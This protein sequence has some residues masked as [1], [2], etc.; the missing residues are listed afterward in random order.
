MGSLS[1]SLRRPLR[2]AVAAKEPS[3]AQLFSEEPTATPAAV[4]VAA[5]AVAAAPPLPAKMEERSTSQA[6]AS[7]SAIMDDQEPSSS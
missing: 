1:R 6:S 3:S 2:S 5:E 4:E 7:L